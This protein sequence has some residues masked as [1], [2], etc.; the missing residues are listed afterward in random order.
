MSTRRRTG[1]LISGRGSNLQALIDAAA[2][3]GFPAEIGL[4]LS[5]KADAYGLERA[6]A[7][8]IATATISH[9][10]FQDRASFDLAMDRLLREAGCELLCL[11]GFMRILSDGFVDIWRGRSIN[12]HPSLLPAY[13]GLNTHARALAD[14]ASNHGC[15]VHF[16]TPGLDEGPAILQAAVPV[17]P[18][19]DEAS[20]AARVLGR[21]HEIYPK[22][23]AWLAEGRATL[24]G[25]H[26]LIDGKPGPLLV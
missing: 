6:K 20:L 12:I 3:P 10:D 17:L 8:G 26:A 7:A 19:D 14:G 18:G 24:E 21:E 15:T 22:A 4:V 2:D 13:R 1:V 23:L 16:V 25:D 11:A 9:R 5:N